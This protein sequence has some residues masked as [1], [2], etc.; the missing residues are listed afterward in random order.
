MVVGDSRNGSDR[1]GV[2]KGDHLPLV[3]CICDRAATFV[4]VEQ[5]RQKSSQMDW[6]TSMAED[7]H[8]GIRGGLESAYQRHDE[9]DEKEGMERT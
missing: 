8:H 5:Q 1:K 7:C 6:T 3:S 2:R 4:E 9:N